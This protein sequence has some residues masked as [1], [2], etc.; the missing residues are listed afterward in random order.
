MGKKI[1]TLIKTVVWNKYFLSLLVFGA[2]I[3][4]FDQHNLL[5][6]LTTKKHLGELVADTVFYNQKI[7]EE[8]EK[9]RQL[10]TSPANLEKFAREQYLMKAADEDVF[11]ILKEDVT[12]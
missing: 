4:F 12:K 1:W 6:R 2:W 10:Q 3:L 11:V 7:R 9:I 8:R 5:D